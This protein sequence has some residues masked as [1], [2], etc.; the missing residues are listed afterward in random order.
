MIE[1]KKTVRNFFIFGIC[2]LYVY[3]FTAC[4]P[5][6][7]AAYDLYN[8]KTLR[9]SA[10]QAVDA[11]DWVSAGD[12]EQENSELQERIIRLPTG[13]SNNKAALFIADISGGQ[14][15]YPNAEG[16]TSLDTRMI[17]PAAYT[18]CKDLIEG[19]KKRE[20]NADF[21]VS[22][23]AFLKIVYEYELKRLPAVKNGLIGKARIDT[24]GTFEIPV[25]LTAEN[26][27]VYLSVYLTRRGAEN[28]QGDVFKI[29][30]IVFEE[31]K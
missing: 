10:L 20:L 15:V 21:F 18:V 13:N 24:N 23:Y 30:Q 31:K 29:E 1:R 4:K 8:T 19:C 7:E 2:A 28:T 3:V 25:R 12:D 16:F 26:G 17:P 11:V 14:P 9:S 6:T 22:E 27:F 5:Q